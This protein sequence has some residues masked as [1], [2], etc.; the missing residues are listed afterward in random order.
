MS[1][2]NKKQLENLEGGVRRA[3]EARS[4]TQDT[5]TASKASKSA[6]KHERNMQT[7]RR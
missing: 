4:R 5:S 1:W 2:K 3:V 6:K 7:S